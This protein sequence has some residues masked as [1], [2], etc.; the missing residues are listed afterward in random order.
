MS[1]NNRKSK[2]VRA[3]RARRHRQR[4]RRFSDRPRLVVYRSA[5]HIY[6]QV[7]DD[8]DS[9][10]LAAASTLQKEFAGNEEKLTGVNAAK[11]VGKKIAEKSLDAGVKQVVFDKGKYLYHGRVKALADSAREAGLDF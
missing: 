3:A 2:E 1:D 9:K 4:I 11:W 6:A 5:K 7:I 8:K 10:T